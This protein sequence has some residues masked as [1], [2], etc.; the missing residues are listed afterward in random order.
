MKIFV[1]NFNLSPC[2]FLAVLM[3]GYLISKQIMAY[4]VLFCHTA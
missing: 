3:P 2:V 1:H 4:F